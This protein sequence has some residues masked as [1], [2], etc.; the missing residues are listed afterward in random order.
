VPY[1]FYQVLYQSI[2][3]QPNTY[4]GS[5]EM[6]DSLMPSFLCPDCDAYSGDYLSHVF[7]VTVSTK[8][9]TNANE[10][11]PTL[12]ETSVRAFRTFTAPNQV[13]VGPLITQ[14]RIKGQVCSKIP[15]NIEAIK[16]FYRTGDTGRGVKPECTSSGRANNG[17]RKYDLRPF[18]YD[19]TFMATSDLYRESNYLQMTSLYK[20]YN[21]STGERFYR[22]SWESDSWPEDYSTAMDFWKVVTEKYTE[23]W[24]DEI[25]LDTLVPYGFFWDGGTGSDDVTGFPVFFDINANKSRATELV[26][27]LDDGKYFDDDLT[28]VATTTMLLFNPEMGIFSYIQISANPDPT[29]GL[30]FG[31]SMDLFDADY[32][33]FAH[34]KT[35]VL[36]T[37]FE[38]IFVLKLFYLVWL[39]VQEFIDLVQ[40]G[41]PHKTC[42]A[43]AAASW[44][45]LGSWKNMIDLTSYVVLFSAVGTWISI[46][47][48][49]ISFWDSVELR[50]DLY[51]QGTMGVGRLFELNKEPA[52]QAY[53]MLNQ[54][55]II[56][57]FWARYVTLAGAALFI[58]V[59]QVLKN[60][61]FHPK[62]GLVSKTFAA[63]ATDL[64]FF[65]VLFIV[66][67]T[68]YSFIGCLVFGNQTDAFSGMGQG[69]LSTL[70]M[71]IGNYVPQDDIGQ[72]NWTSIFYWIY[73]ALANFLLLNALLAIV[74]GAYDNVVSDAEKVTEDDIINIMYNEV[75]AGEYR[76]GE[77]HVTL[78]T[79]MRC[80]TVAKEFDGSTCWWFGEAAEGKLSPRSGTMRF[81]VHETAD[82][83]AHDELSAVQKA[84]GEPERI[85]AMVVV[86][87]AD[88][89]SSDQTATSKPQFLDH[90]MVTAVFCERL[91]CPHEIGSIIAYNMMMNYGINVEDVDKFFDD[92]IL[93]KETVVEVLLQNNKLR[94]AGEDDMSRFRRSSAEANGRNPDNGIIRHS[95][96]R[97]SSAADR[98]SLAEDTDALA[99]LDA[100]DDLDAP[101]AMDRVEL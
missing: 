25:D 87:P 32:Y 10:M 73:T 55:Q 75:F 81:A 54:A 24:S 86:L 44:R 41:R 2:M 48:V 14:A 7:N 9:S 47:L 66:I 30:L 57:R 59:V 70:Q 83:M 37:L 96:V 78:A 71:L 91:G 23:I 20:V 40:E 12:D 72:D 79:L 43:W 53:D 36:R 64:S 90:G 11:F 8:S 50:F 88:K 22:P 101:G 82:K 67:H 3:A 6:S 35:D 27:L 89:L 26:Q 74:L 99:F 18:G 85:Q 69:W 19:G 45:Y 52:E 34:N 29:G 46:T 31:S 39:E 1:N 58:L 17:F 13:L 42:Q 92:E 56:A 93:S 51:A 38:I 5:S 61:D 60:L 62:M 63:A 95:E 76:A 80:L 94:Q 77:F 100:P 65:T 28:A 21:S 4:L 33:D 15:Y 16:Q 98:K 97:R 68:I 84:A 49:N